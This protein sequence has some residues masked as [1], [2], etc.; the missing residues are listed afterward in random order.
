MSPY[1]LRP[2]PVR[3]IQFDGSRAAAS[4]IVSLIA[5]EVTARLRVEYSGWSDLVRH[6]EI[7]FKDQ[8]HYCGRGDWVVLIGPDGE[9]RPMV[10]TQSEFE[11]Y[12]EPSA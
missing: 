7:E 1:R 10:L 3:A 5:P 9:K 12:F 4:A 2:F 8:D 6:F 11:R